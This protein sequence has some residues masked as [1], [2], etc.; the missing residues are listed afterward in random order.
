MRLYRGSTTFVSSIMVLPTP[1][2]IRC[3]FWRVAASA[4]KPGSAAHRRCGAERGARAA[5]SSGCRDKRHDQRA[6]D[7]NN[8]TGGAPVNRAAVPRR[9]RGADASLH[10]D[11][12]LSLDDLPAEFTAGS[13]VVFHWHDPRPALGWTARGDCGHPVA[14]PGDSI[15]Q[16]A[17]FC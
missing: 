13:L 10:L 11:G 15:T 9:L 5:V 7:R 3:L 8:G 2:P 14:R 16:S 17:I 12:H 4:R 6:A 1:Y